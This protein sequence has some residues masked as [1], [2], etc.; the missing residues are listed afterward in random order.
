LPIPW[1]WKDKIDDWISKMGYHFVIREVE[2][3]T[4]VKRG[5]RLTLKL[6]VENVG[7][8]PIYY[9]LPLYVRLKNDVFTKDFETEIDIRNWLEGKYEECLEIALPKD[10]LRG[11][12]ELQVGIGGKGAPSVVFATDALQDGDYSIL[13]ELELM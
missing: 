10:M 13:T 12:Y 6:V 11:N 1:E 7:V 8:A 3:E 2:T 4:S 5:E 9:Q